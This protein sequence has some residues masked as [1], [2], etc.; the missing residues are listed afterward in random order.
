[1]FVTLRCN[2]D[3]IFVKDAPATTRDGTQPRRSANNNGGLKK[4]AATTQ[5]FRARR[6]TRRKRRGSRDKAQSTFGTED[7][8]IE[9][10]KTHE[11]SR[12]NDTVDASSGPMPVPMPKSLESELYIPDIFQTSSN[13][14]QPFGAD[15]ISNSPNP[16]GGITSG[17]FDAIDY[18]NEDYSALEQRSLPESAISHPAISTFATGPD[19]ASTST[20]PRKYSEFSTHT[21]PFESRS[22]HLDM[23]LSYDSANI[24][25]TPICICLAD[26]VDILEKLE[27]LEFQD[28]KA[29]TNTVD[30]ILSLNKNAIAKCKLMLDC[31]NCQLFSSRMMLLILIGR[32]LVLQFE[33]LLPK[34]SS[35][36]DHSE[37][38]TYGD[39][40]TCVY[41]QICSEKNASL[42]RYSVETSEELKDLLRVLAITQGRSLGA[43]IERARSIAESR[44]W[45]VHQSILENR[46]PVP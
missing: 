39:L 15:W 41:G 1:M 29:P 24:G 43:F 18:D 10:G 46:T 32:N 30:G 40:G 3:G 16:M 42:G 4:P 22:R 21:L 34:F 45:M 14:E 33:Q 2:K 8:R 23:Q 27:I 31:T 7:P 12:S 13:D 6:E 20:A 38:C 11:E 25:A 35:A 9:S 26:V 36:G 17:V 44:N 28:D 37:A 5:A 19:D